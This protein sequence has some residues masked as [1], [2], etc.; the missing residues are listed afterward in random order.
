MTTPKCRTCKDTG[1][2]P[3]EYGV[4]PCSMCEAWES[5]AHV[6]GI[7]D[8]P[9][10]PA[11]HAKD[12]DDSS[13]SLFATLI[14]LIVLLLA[15]IAL[16]W[17]EEARAETLGPELVTNGTFEVDDYWSLGYSWQILPA[18][19][20]LAFHNEGYTA[21]I[22]QPIAELVTGH[23]Y[24]VRYTI[25]GSAGSTD[26]RHWFRMRGTSGYASCPIASGDGTFGCDIVAPASAMSILIRPVYG[27]GGV[28]DDVSVR[29]V[30]P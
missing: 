30:T 5:R 24:R 27:F 15:S 19:G 13:D 28:L 20:A 11:Y 6:S 18:P 17:P 3:A 1:L 23:T 22:E 10:T 14:V 29:E 25:S 12:E 7:D 9:I 2:I 4:Q 26:P 21:P 16:I 8:E